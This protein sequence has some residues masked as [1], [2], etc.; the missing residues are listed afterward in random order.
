MRKKE[1]KLSE[2]IL[3]TSEV[4]TAFLKKQPI[5]ALE[6][7]V[8]THGLPYPTNL[9]MA[10]SVEMLIRK[11]GAIPATIG[12][13]QGKIRVGLPDEVLTDLSK[14]PDLHKI[15]TR[16]LGIALARNWS[17]GTTVAATMHI[18]NLVGIKVFATG[19]IGGVH[20]GNSLDISADIPGLS[21]TPMVVVCAG[22]KAILD[23]PATLE[24]LET[25]AV[26]VIGYQTNELPAFYSAKSG[27]PVDLRLD[28]PAEIAQ[29]ATQH[30]ALGLQSALLVCNPPPSQ[31]DIP[32]EKINAVI[33]RA[34]K[35]AEKAHISGPRVTPFLLDQ[36]RVQTGGES[37]RSNIALLENNARLAAEISLA[38][39]KTFTHRR[40]KAI[41]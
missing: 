35:A 21:R 30:W 9:E 39:S 10:Q 29:L 11:A 13:H 40:V 6:T 17:G 37:L 8:I 27:L 25:N 23:L 28:S 14:A 3:I 4:Q 22:A 12:L 20:R 31:F 16:N 7:A 38:M 15:S 32:L 41:V 26:P 33:D 1:M 24:V 5:V 18:A 36:V 2:Q 34:L 19:G